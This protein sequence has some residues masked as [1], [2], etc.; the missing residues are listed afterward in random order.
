M[1]TLISEK[2]QAIRTRGNIAQACT[3]QSHLF[4]L[5]PSGPRLLG[6]LVPLLGGQVNTTALLLIMS[7][8]QGDEPKTK[9]E[10][11]GVLKKR[12]PQDD[13]AVYIYPLRQ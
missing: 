1:K 3:S 7:H 9:F 5:T 13:E 12:R 2:K 10:A 6:V 8:W 11:E 4:L